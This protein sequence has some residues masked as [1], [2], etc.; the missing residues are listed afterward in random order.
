MDRSRLPT[1]RLVIFDL[2]GVVYRGHQPIQ[3]AAALVASLRRAGALVRFATN[4]SMATRPA[5]IAR[6][7]EMGVPAQL[8]EIVTSTS[9]TI[10][11]LRAHEPG[12]R[13][14]LAVG[15]PGMVAEL[16]AAGLDATAAAE[17]A[18]SGYDGSGLAADYDA[19]VAGLDPDFDYQRL[20][21]AVTAL[22]QGARFLATNADPRFPTPGG[23][24]PGAGAMVAAL[25]AS[26]GVEPLIIGKPQPGMFRT[27]LE[28]AGVE[29]GAALAIGDN[30][31]TD[32]V[33]ARRAGIASLL[34]LTGVTDEAAARDLS[35]ERQPDWIARGPAEVAS[36]LGISL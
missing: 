6:L 2:D 19:V 4:N 24:L 18:P 5:Y 31:L 23:I 9:A 8:D 12:V 3:G 33:A 27:I 22:R 11:H 1:P 25:E 34:V 35:G 28:L 29:P 7:E 20:A 30:P 36:L 17:A 21:A 14:I 16:R 15:A 13:R 26:S 32:V 10:D